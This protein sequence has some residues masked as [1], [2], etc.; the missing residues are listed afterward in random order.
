MTWNYRYFIG[1]PAA[2]TA[3]LLITALA[4]GSA[5]AEESIACDGAKEC[6]QKAEGFME[7]GKYEQAIACY[8]RTLEFAGHLAIL[9]FYLGL[10][11]RFNGSKRTAREHFQKL[12]AAVADGTVRKRDELADLADRFLIEIEHSMK[13]DRIAAEERR[14]LRRIHEKLERGF[15]ELAERHGEAAVVRYRKRYVYILANEVLLEEPRVSKSSFAKLAHL[16]EE[17]REHKRRPVRTESKGMRV[18]GAVIGG[19]GLITLG[20]ALRHGLGA[21]TGAD[22]DRDRNIGLWVGTGAAVAAIVGWTMFHHGGR[23]RARSGKRES[24]SKK[25]FSVT[26]TVS[27]KSWGLAIAGSF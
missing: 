16:E 13:R 1:K 14:E 23:K 21:P 20:V 27:P 8:Q 11:H 5:G 15:D 6:Y 19:S 25:G 9:H 18:M 4:A 22:G 2:A 24:R 26:P 10:A 17:I 3:L 12:L 7:Q